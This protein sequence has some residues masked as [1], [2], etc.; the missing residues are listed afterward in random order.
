MVISRA[1]RALCLTATTA[2]AFLTSPLRVA[3]VRPV[4]PRA[5]TYLTA[6]QRE[7]V[8]TTTTATG[9]VPRSGA[10]K[11]A[12]VGLLGVAMFSSGK[13]ADAADGGAFQKTDS[14][15]QYQI[16]KAGTGAEPTPGQSVSVNYSGWL[17]G[18]EDNGR[19]FDSSYDR[20]RP[21][22]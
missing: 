22:R 1:L 3:P 16:V 2:S 12:L 21:F 14:G 17:D 9:L 11:N 15:L 4:V 13:R 5:L 8:T 18:F 6:A 19:K 20:R 10:V 7:P